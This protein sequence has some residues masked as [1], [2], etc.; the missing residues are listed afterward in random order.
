MLRY[1]MDKYSSFGNNP[2]FQK[3]KDKLEETIKSK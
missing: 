3:Y 2:I 1:R